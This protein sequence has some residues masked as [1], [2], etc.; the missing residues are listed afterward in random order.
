MKWP[1]RKRE[2]RCGFCRPPKSREVE[3][4]DHECHER[5]EKR[6]VMH[7]GLEIDLVHCKECALTHRLSCYNLAGGCGEKPCPFARKRREP[8]Y[9]CARCDVPGADAMMRGLPYHRQCAELELEEIH[10]ELELDRD[11]AVR[12]IWRNAFRFTVISWVIITVVFLLLHLFT[13]L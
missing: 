2:Q 1:T 6:L 9:L 5:W 8:L 12:R 13:D 4:A 7:R 10:K 11:K 3:Q